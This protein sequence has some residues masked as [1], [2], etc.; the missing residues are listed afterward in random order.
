MAVFRAE[1]A[2]S[3]S[4]PAFPRVIDLSRQD[5]LEPLMAIVCGASSHAANCTVIT[6]TA[7]SEIV[8]LLGNPQ[9]LPP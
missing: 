6:I 9:L 1:T 3:F 4:N 2:D 8:D 7:S 5:R